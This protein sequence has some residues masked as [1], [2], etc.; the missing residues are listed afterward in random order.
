MP[1]GVDH[2][3]LRRHAS[4]NAV[5]FCNEDL[6]NSECQSSNV[7]FFFASVSCSSYQRFCFF[8][9]HGE[10]W[11]EPTTETKFGEFH[12]WSYMTHEL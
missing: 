12:R 5:C 2:A 3:Q 9:T 11:T 1:E 4:V 6:C 7:L 10:I 8:V